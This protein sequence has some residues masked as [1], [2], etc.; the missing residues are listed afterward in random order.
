MGRWKV[1]ETEAAH[2]RMADGKATCTSPQCENCIHVRISGVQIGAGGFHGRETPRTFCSICVLGVPHESAS[3]PGKHSRISSPPITLRLLPGY[4][5]YLSLSDATR[6]SLNFT[7]WDGWMWNCLG[8]VRSS[9]KTVCGLVCVPAAGPPTGALHL[10]HFSPWGPTRRV[11]STEPVN[12][13]ACGESGDQSTK[14]AIKDLEFRS[15]GFPGWA[16][17]AI[18]VLP[19]HSGRGA[20]DHRGR[21]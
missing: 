1:L 21:G 8:R 6:L 17:N 10:C 7:R 11:I 12:V 16:L 20:R 13:S 3:L 9:D 15:P 2:L 14:D 19:T 18:S 5:D 4:C